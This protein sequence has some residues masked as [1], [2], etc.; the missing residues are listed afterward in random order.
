MV[1]NVFDIIT[2]YLKGDVF[3][4]DFFEQQSSDKTLKNQ[5]F[6][7]KSYINFYKLIE[8]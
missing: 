2:S 3:I 8:H 4:L 1:G 7:Q 5:V 6:L